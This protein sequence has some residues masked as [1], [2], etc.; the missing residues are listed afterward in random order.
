M[1][2]VTSQDVGIN[3]DTL[4]TDSQNGWTWDD[5]WDTGASKKKSWVPKLLAEKNA[6]QREADELRAELESLKAN[7]I[8]KDNLDETLELLTEKK[9][10]ISSLDEDKIEEFNTLSQ[11][12]PNL[13]PSQIAK[14]MDVQMESSQPNRLS[15]PWNTPASLKKRQTLSDKSDEELR[16]WAI[17]ELNA[18]LG[19]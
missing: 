16:A 7:S 11:Q 3:T 13:K 6:A 14:L 1:T 4:D 19:R 10:V 18:L 8:S 5:T 17:E 2:E 15:M 12:N 9:M